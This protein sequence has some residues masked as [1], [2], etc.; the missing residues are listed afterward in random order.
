MTLNEKLG[1]EDGKR[2]NVYKQGVFWVAY[3]ESAAMLCCEKAL[4]VRG[5]YEK[6]VGREI[7]SVGF[8]EATLEYFRGK[9]GHLEVETGSVL[10]SQQMKSEKQ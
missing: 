3:E 6:Q 2:I 1:R 10:G 8:P 5:R 7:L 9:F 4:K